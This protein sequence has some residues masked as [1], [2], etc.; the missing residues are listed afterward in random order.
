MMT[1]CMRN[2]SLAQCLA[3]SKNLIDVSEP[4]SRSFFSFNLHSCQPWRI[5]VFWEGW[6]LSCSVAVVVAQGQW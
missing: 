2:D 3:H 4:S 5:E 1:G 6:G